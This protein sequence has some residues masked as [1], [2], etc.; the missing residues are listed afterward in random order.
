MGSCDCVLSRIDLYEMCI[1]TC[2]RPSNPCY[3]CELYF[4]KLLE[5]KVPKCEIFNLLDFHD[6]YTLKPLWLG[7]FR[8]VIKNSKAF[9][10]FMVSKFVW[11]NKFLSSL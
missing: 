8:A 6:F 3:I 1:V 9:C 2:F 7:D 11:R 4:C 10:L 5:L